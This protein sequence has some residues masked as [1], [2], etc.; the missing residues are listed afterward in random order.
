MDVIFSEATG[1][2]F[3]L[4]TIDDPDSRMD[5]VNGSIQNASGEFARFLYTPRCQR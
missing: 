5:V 1:D 4:E 2:A 3:K